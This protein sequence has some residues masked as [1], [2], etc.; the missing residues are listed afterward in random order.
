MNRSVA[1][2]P[3]GGAASCQAGF[4]FFYGNNTF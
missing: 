3:G 4:C 2:L 1:T